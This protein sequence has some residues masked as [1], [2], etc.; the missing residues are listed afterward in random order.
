VI[1]EIKYHAKKSVNALLREAMKQI[2][3][4]RYYNQYT[5]KVILLGIAFSGKNAGCRMKS[6]NS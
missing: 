4:R 2:N 1:A 3:D 5:G 6:H